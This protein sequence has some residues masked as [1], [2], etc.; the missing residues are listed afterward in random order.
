ML[1]SAFQ[2]F[3]DAVYSEN[4]LLK[5][6]VC[7]L[8]FVWCVMLIIDVFALIKQSATSVK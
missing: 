2:W 1:E 5:T 3:L 4:D 6:T 7:M 8:A